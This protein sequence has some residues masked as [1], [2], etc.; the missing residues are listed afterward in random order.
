[1][2][3]AG[4]WSDSYQF[5]DSRNQNAGTIRL[6]WLT[7]KIM[8]G[9]QGAQELSAKRTLGYKDGLTSESREV[10]FQTCHSMNALQYK[11]PQGIS[12]PALGAVKNLQLEADV[13]TSIKCAPS[14]HGLNPHVV[15]IAWLLTTRDDLMSANA[16]LI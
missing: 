5:H 1:M 10:T 4:S 8:A 7:T 3:A 15:G 11:K 13:A 16:R 2:V 6:A 9:Y 12:H 14:F